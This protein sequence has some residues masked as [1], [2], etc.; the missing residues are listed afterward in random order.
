[1]SN[2][3]EKVGKSS[4]IRIPVSLVPVYVAIIIQFMGVVFMS[5]V[6]YNKMNEQGK[7]LDKFETKLDEYVKI[8]T[9]DV[10]RKADHAQFE[11]SLAAHLKDD[12]MQFKILQ[13]RVTNLEKNVIRLHPNFNPEVTNGNNR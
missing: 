13:D 8:V 1:M 11:A 6:I 10:W 5:G 3:E 7:K 4:S 9:I 2:G 12:D